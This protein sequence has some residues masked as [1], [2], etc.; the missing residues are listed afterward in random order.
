VEVVAVKLLWRGNA[1]VNARGPS[2]LESPDAVLDGDNLQ[3]I[4]GSVGLR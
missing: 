3:A 4:R 2:K 1:V